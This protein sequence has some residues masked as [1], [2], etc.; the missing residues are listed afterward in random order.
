MIAIE[1]S[2]IAGLTDGSLVDGHDAGKGEFNIFIRCD[3]PQLTF[4]IARSILEDQGVFADIRA[5]YREATGT[6]YITLWPQKLKHFG[7][8]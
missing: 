5:A 2:L 6:K 8:A 1:D 4:G 3:E 7:V